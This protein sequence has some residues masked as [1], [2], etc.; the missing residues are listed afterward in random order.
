M[1]ILIRMLVVC[2]FAISLYGQG[3]DLDKGI[4]LYQEDKL[5]EAIAVLSNVVAADKKEQRAWKY[6]GAAYMKTGR[7][8][9]A[10]IAFKNAPTDYKKDPTQEEYRYE[11]PLKMIYNRPPRYT[12]QAREDGVQGEVRLIVELKSDG[13]IG[14]IY[15]A[16]GLPSGL[17]EAAIA[18]AKTIKFEP[19]I[20]KGRPV[21]VVTVL[22]YTFGHF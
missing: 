18:Q 17:T 6:I 12:Q 22:A 7:Q 4:D 21:S 11:R 13:T 16:A 20:R 15:V 5:D 2:A 8:K 14:F 9:E 10:R 1:K 19:A 3:T